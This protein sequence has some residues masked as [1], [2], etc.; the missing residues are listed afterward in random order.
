MTY[1][2]F[3]EYA[4]IALYLVILA[5]IAVDLAVDYLAAKGGAR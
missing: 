4:E 5:F 1:T 2:D 3:M